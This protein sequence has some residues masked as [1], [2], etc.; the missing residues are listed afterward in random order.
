[1]KLPND[2][3]SYL[4]H[5]KSFDKLKEEFGIY[6]T[7]HP[8][9]P[10]VILKYDQIE[11]PKFHPIV[12]QCRGTVVTKD[13]PYNIVSQGFTRFYNFGE[14]WSGQDAFNWNNFTCNEKVD[15]SLVCLWN[16]NNE[17]HISL[18][19]SFGLQEIVEG[20]GKSWKDVIFELLKLNEEIPLHEGEVYP[21]MNRGELLDPDCTYVF[22][23]CS[24]YN[25]IVREYK[26][27]K[28]FL[29]SVFYKNDD[30]IY[31]PS[32]FEVD[33]IASQLKFER[34]ESY[35][36]K[37]LKEVEQF[38]E[39]QE[40]EDS[41]W[42]GVVLKDSNNIRFKLKSRM[43]L[44]LH[45]LK[46][47]G[48]VFLP[49]NILPWIIKGEEAE[50][51]SYFGELTDTVYRMKEMLDREF[52]TLVKVWEEAWQIESQKDFALTI[53]PQTK[54]NG[55]LFTLRK[56][57]GKLQTRGQLEELWRHSED[58]ILKVLFKEI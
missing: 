32:K 4:R 53:V 25:K 11:S 37:S 6:S 50:L 29:L 16:Y 39:K 26:T 9:L 12:R 44:T 15:G 47:N 49:K 27:P 57:Y 8:T 2:L 22:E 34:P 14:D 45:N 35:D 19:G 18:S 43:Y 46:G 21:T 17:W 20:L 13:Y 51:L 38:I 23:L 30:N 36:F 56:K 10:L 41:T 24:M 55:L 58:L 28:L 33:F 42:E 7:E 52:N 3:Q 54:F 5:W 1:M 48:N 31:E 40:T